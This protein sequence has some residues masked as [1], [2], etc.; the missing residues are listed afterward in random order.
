[1]TA[2]FL[3]LIGVAVLGGVLGMAGVVALIVAAVRRRG[4]TAIIGGIGLLVAFLMIG[5]GAIGA[6]VVAGIGVTGFV[7]QVRAENAAKW[8][9]M[10]PNITALKQHEPPG[11]T[12][13][14]EFYEYWGHWDYYRVPLVYPYSFEM[15]D[16]STSPATLNR[17][18]GIDSVA[19]NPNKAS[20]GVRDLSDITHVT[21]DGRYL[22][23]QRNDWQ[24]GTEFVL[25]DMQ[26]DEDQRFTTLP[27]LLAA[28]RNVGYTG[29]TTLVT[30]GS[31]YDNYWNA[32]PPLGTIA[33][34]TQPA[35]TQPPTQPR[36]QAAF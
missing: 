22:L 5:G 35:T 16:S 24:D 34:T 18:T 31:Y 27:D 9:A 20:Q 30:L 28:T 32:L 25:F 29:P 26:T 15:I 13:P 10:Q 17:D 2:I 33:P 12:V 23:L 36:P 6:V 4:S 11:A 14:D 19:D 7:Q 21:Y 3:S 1:M 8:A